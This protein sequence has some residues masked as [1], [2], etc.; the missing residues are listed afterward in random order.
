MI[1]DAAAAYTET[2]AAW[3]D[4]P[5]R[6]YD[7][8]AEEIVARCPSVRDGALVLDI[9]AGT[10]A[11]SRAATR[12]GA[13]VVALDAAIGMLAVD[14]SVRPPA[15]V[16]DAS[17]LPFAGMSFDAAI[18]AFSLNHVAEPARALRE[19][20]RLLRPGGSIVASSY[21]ADD[22][23]PVKAA[24]NA[25][26]VARGWVPDEWYVRLAR[27]VVPIMASVDGVA[28]VAAAAGLDGA[29]VARLTVH[30][31]ELTPADL[32]AWRLGHVQLAP[33]VNRLPIAERDALA[34]DALARLGTS[35]PLTRSIIV[36]SYVDAR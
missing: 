4:G 11:A 5:G 12:N 29:T 14:A 7:R 6:I 25:A 20:A 24:A 1:S 13:K 35:P 15:V 32:V 30:F 3:R 23:H 16:G 31:P 26:A 2:G 19:A 17:L 9:G 21:G 34:A 18:A 33:F 27:D 10:G 22:S 8:L 36:L 28:A